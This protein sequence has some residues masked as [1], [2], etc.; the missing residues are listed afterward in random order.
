MS[1]SAHMRLIQ[2]PEAFLRQGRALNF[3]KATLN[4]CEA[5]APSD[6][7]L[8]SRSDSL[9][10]TLSPQSQGVKAGAPKDRL[11]H[12]HSNSMPTAE[13][14]FQ[15]PPGIS[16]QPLLPTGGNTVP[17]PA[18]SSLSHL[19]RGRELPQEMQCLSRYCPSCLQ[20]LAHTPCPVLLLPATGELSQPV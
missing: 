7:T 16:S 2:K 11:C 13:W 10:I 19:L 3:V 18:H 8:S 20:S 15:P 17:G 4:N 14:L 9:T 6:H 1:A 5:A 12:L